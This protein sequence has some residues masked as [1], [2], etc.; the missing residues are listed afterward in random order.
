MLRQGWRDIK[1]RKQLASERVLAIRREIQRGTHLLSDAQCRALLEDI[2]YKSRLEDELLGVVAPFDAGDGSVDPGRHARGARAVAAKLTPI[3]E[4]ADRA[5][6]GAE[7]NGQRSDGCDATPFVTEVRQLHE[8][9]ATGESQRADFNIVGGTIKAQDRKCWKSKRES[10]LCGAK[11]RAAH[12]Q[13]DAGAPP[14]GGYVAKAGRRRR[15]RRVSEPRRDGP[16]PQ[17]AGSG[18]DAQV[19]EPQGEDEQSSPARVSVVVPRNLRSQEKR[20]SPKAGS[21]ARGAAPER[22]ADAPGTSSF[23]LPSASSIQRDRQ[24]DCV[25]EDAGYS[26]RAGA[27][28]M[29]RDPLLGFIPAKGGPI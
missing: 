17:Q 29:I 24:R 25:L 21:E 12:G 5:S 11:A 7:G 2:I 22:E 27:V 6:R 1:E 3:P 20:R 23:M 13:A 19:C 15:S 28:P 16:G 14:C 10:S 26:G 4:E 18:V 8:V 9:G